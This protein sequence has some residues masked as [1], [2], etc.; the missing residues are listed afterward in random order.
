MTDQTCR[1]E[2][3][4]EDVDQDICGDCGYAWDNLTDIDSER[5]CKYCHGTGQ[6]WDLA[7]CDYCD[8][9]GIEWWA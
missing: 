5:T 4:I 1:H 7:E 2:H 8:G 3:I 6:D 9:T